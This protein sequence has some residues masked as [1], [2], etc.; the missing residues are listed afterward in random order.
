MRES[1]KSSPFIRYYYM[2]REGVPGAKGRGAVDEDKMK[3]GDTD[4]GC[5][6]GNEGGDVGAWNGV[7]RIFVAQKN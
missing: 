6:I 2:S 4:T 3:S 1:G 7:Y 5:E